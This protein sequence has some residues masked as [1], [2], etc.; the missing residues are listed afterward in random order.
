MKYIGNKAKNQ[1]NGIIYYMYRINKT[2]V[3][4]LIFTLI[5]S[6]LA[7]SIIVKAYNNAYSSVDYLAE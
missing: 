2:L 6:A 3:Y 4:L 5:S 7:Y 1:E